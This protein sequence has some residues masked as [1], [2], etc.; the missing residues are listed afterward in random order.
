MREVQTP[1]IDRMDTLT[2]VGTINIIRT[3]LNLEQSEQFA[4]AHGGSLLTV[5]EWEVL[6]STGRKLFGEE[7]SWGRGADGSGMCFCIVSPIFL[8][9][10]RLSLMAARK[11]PEFVAEILVYKTD[12]SRITTPQNSGLLRPSK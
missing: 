8:S 10:N 12:D 1:K 2:R 4:K 7:Y 3:K 11:K 9:I 6:R 5:Q